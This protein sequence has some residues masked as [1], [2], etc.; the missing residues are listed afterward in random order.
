MKHLFAPV[1]ALV[2]ATGA[3]QAQTMPGMDMDHHDHQ[4]PASPPD[5]TAPAPAPSPDEPVG[6]DQ[7]PGSA[8]APPP[9]HDR[10][11]DRF[12]DPQAMAR[13][14][15]AMM[16]P[17]LAHYSQVRLDLAEYQFRQGHDGYRWE[18]EAWTGNLNRFVSRS[19]GEG[20]VGAGLD[21]A[22]LQG[23][24]SRA[25]DP[26]WNLQVGV[27]QDIRPK[28]SRT[29]ART[30]ATIGVEGTAP[31]RFDVQAAAFLSDKGQLTARIETALDQRLTRRLV[32]EPRLELN[33]SAQDMPVERLGPGLTSAELGLRLRYEIRRQLAPY[34]GLSWTWA[35]GKTATY[36]RADG[37]SPRQRGVVVGLRAWF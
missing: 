4:H 24:Y 20:T 5:A 11:A 32:L 35:A 18:G 36:A 10:A 31:Y 1:L 7:S 17:P 26:W 25:L 13:A 29:P 33:L 23:L 12:Y 6:T 8:E 19:R 21:S 15:A 2:F 28:P 9:A 34:V 37:E 3:A 30:H 22:E 14:E 27:R 16:R